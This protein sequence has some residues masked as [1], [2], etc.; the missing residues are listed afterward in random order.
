[1]PLDPSTPTGRE[2]IRLAV[3]QIHEHAYAAAGNTPTDIM[4][5]W[6]YQMVRGHETVIQTRVFPEGTDSRVVVVPA[7]PQVAQHVADWHP[8]QAL[9]VAAL[10]EVIGREMKNCPEEVVR[11]AVDVAQGLIT[12]HRNDECDDSCTV[13][14]HIT[15]FR[16]KSG[17]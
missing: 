8:S 10:L 2:A 14:H 13:W 11:R 15:E 1:M 16:K 7:E 5:C 9:S 3:E 12:D 17:G 6:Q 4:C